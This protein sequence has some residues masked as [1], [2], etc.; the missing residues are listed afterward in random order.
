[1][2]SRDAQYKTKARDDAKLNDS[3]DFHSFTPPTKPCQG[4]IDYFLNVLFF[5]N[6]SLARH[7]RT[8]IMVFFIWLNPLCLLAV[9]GYAIFRG[10]NSQKDR[11]RSDPNS[12]EFQGNSI[13][14]NTTWYD[15]TATKALNLRDFLATSA[16]GQPKASCRLSK[17]KYSTAEKSLIG[18]LILKYWNQMANLLFG[19]PCVRQRR[20]RIVIMFWNQSTKFW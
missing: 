9:I 17:K 15:A 13:E 6:C 12:E 5:L 18:R 14:Y 19:L 11:F 16:S 7:E 4:M 8:C 20:K 2:R 10:A 1:M 3:P